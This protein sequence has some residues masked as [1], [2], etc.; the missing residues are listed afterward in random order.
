MR[1]ASGKVAARKCRDELSEIETYLA[2]VQGSSLSKQSRSRCY[3][4][5][6]L[7]LC[8]AL[9]RMVVEGLIVAINND[10]KALKARTGIEFPH[11]NRAASEYLIMGDGYFN[12]NGTKDGMMRAVRHYLDRSHWLVKALSTSDAKT[13]ARLFSLRNWAAHESAASGRAA[14]AAIGMNAGSAGSWLKSGTRM[15]VLIDHVRKIANNVEAAAP[16]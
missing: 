4:L 16:Y 7:K 5:A 1:K 9:E 2:D 14:R 11:L 13:L 3:D 8:V 10:R 15:Q 12:F 6:A